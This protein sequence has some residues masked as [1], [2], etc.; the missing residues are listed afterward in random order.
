M[1]KPTLSI[2]EIPNSLTTDIDLAS[3]KGIVK[4]LRAVDAQIYNGWDTYDA[5]C[6]PE[7]IS[8][9]HRAVSE[10]AKVLSFK[11]KKRIIFSGAGTSG[12]LSMFAARTFNHLCE[13]IGIEPC[14]RHMIAGGDLA[15]I[16]AQ[17]GAED[18]PLTAQKELR[19]IVEDAEKIFYVGVTCGFSAAYIAGQLDMAS[20]DPKYFSALLG[21][22][23]PELARKLVIEHWDKKFFDIVQKIKDHPRCVLLNPVVG[24]E[25]ITGSTRMKGGGATKLLIEVVFTAALIKAKILSP[26]NLAHPLKMHAWDMK[27]LITSMIREYENT[28]MDTYEQRDDIARLVELGGLALRSQRHIYYI[29]ADVYG[30]LG[31]IDASECPPTFGATFE[32]VRGYLPAGWPELLNQDR[33]LSNAG[34]EY[35]ISLKDFEEQKLP[36][37]STEDLVIIL[38]HESTI[39]AHEEI[40]EKIKAMEAKLGAVLINPIYKTFPGFDAVVKLRI[41][42]AGLI[43][44]NEMLAEYATKLVI[45]AITTGA[46]ILSGKIY[47]NRMVDLNISNTKLFYRTIDILRDIIGVDKDTAFM[48]VLRSIY[49]TDTPT[50]EQI[51]SPISEHINAGTWKKRIVPRALLMATGKFN[52]EAAGKALDKEP[53]VRAIIEKIA[54]E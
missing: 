35:H 25:A 47:Q 31:T 18:D 19:E 14:F 42:P 50:E 48:S 28:R 39:N 8:N 5:L 52:Y 10:A 7:I 49:K 26:N 29:G 21:F 22:N 44:N 37:L 13:Q 23:P 2:T 40:L 20:D 51:K 53:I 24:P 32:D 41:D 43:L 15:L 1:A 17:E 4:I 30:V 36:H 46:H 16:K 54:V 6:D 9:I 11:G 45:N 27:S 38:G 34:K 33:D 3:P 12:R